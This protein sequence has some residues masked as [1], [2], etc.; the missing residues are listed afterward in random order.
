MYIHPSELEIP[1]ERYS[2][3]GVVRKNYMELN[4]LPKARLLMLCAALS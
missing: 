1:T 3:Y 4:A 2:T